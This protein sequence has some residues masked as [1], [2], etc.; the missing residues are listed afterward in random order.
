MIVLSSNIKLCTFDF[1]NGKDLSDQIAS[2]NI[3]L[4]MLKYYLITFLIIAVPLCLFPIKLFNGIIVLDTSLGE[5][6]FPT[7]LSLSYFFG[8]GY[9]KSDL[10]GVKDFYLTTQG[11]ILV[12]LIL[13]A[14]P[15]LVAYRVYLSKTP[16]TKK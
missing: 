15:A 10:E 1:M 16:K 3:K 2:K 14:L 4:K 13:F 9:E 5:Q 8:I 7:K 6:I 11:K 12:A